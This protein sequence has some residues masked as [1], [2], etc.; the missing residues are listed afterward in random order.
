MTPGVVIDETTGTEDTV[1]VLDCVDSEI[2]SGIMNDDTAGIDFPFDIGT[3]EISTF[4]CVVVIIE[5]FVVV[6][7]DDEAVVVIFFSTLLSSELSAVV[8]VVASFNLFIEV[9]DAVSSESIMVEIIEIV[10]FGDF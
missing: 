7:A 10:V 1:E 4:V 6:T 3:F 9:I 5:L 8:D 2:V